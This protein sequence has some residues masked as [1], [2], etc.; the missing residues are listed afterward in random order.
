MAA[1]HSRYGVLSSGT[2]TYFICVK[3][4]GVPSISNAWRVGQEHYLRAWSHF[5]KVARTAQPLTDEESKQWEQGTPTS[6]SPDKSS[7]S[8]D[9]PNNNNEDDDAGGETQVEQQAH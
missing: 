2:R 8:K 4:D 9:N 3:D 6:K 1:N 7:K 5:F